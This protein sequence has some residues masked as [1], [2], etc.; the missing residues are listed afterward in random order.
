MTL[1]FFFSWMMRGHH[2]GPEVKGVL[3]NNNSREEKAEDEEEEDILEAD[4]GA[5]PAKS[6]YRGMCR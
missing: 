5:A 3:A 4:G 6:K 1:M 2:A